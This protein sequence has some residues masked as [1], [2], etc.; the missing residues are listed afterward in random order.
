MFQL[1]CWPWSSN[2]LIA[3]GDGPLCSSSF[4]LYLS[5]HPFLPSWGLCSKDL[6][7]TTFCHPSGWTLCFWGAGNAFFTPGQ[8]LMVFCPCCPPGTV[9][10][11][12]FPLWN[13]DENPGVRNVLKPLLLF[14][15]LS[16]SQ[17][18]LLEWEGEILWCLHAILDS[19][20]RRESLWAPVLRNIICSGLH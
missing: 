3:A 7:I 10:F 9:W 19:S 8:G 2:L 17:R 11:F 15:C 13:F 6:G 4:L 16:A 14:W 12:A 20:T 5:N 18:W 1:S